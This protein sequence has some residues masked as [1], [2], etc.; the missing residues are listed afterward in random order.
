[1]SGHYEKLFICALCKEEFKGDP[2][3]LPCQHSVCESPCLKKLLGSQPSKCPRCSQE[4]NVSSNTND[5]PT[6]M[7]LKPLVSYYEGYDTLPQKPATELYSDDY[8]YYKET[9]A[10]SRNS[11]KSSV[12]NVD[13]D[14][15][16]RIIVESIS[17]IHD[18][19][20]RIEEIQKNTSLILE[21]NQSVAKNGDLKRLYQTFEQ[22]HIDIKN[23]L[24]SVE[25]DLANCIDNNILLTHLWQCEEHLS[26][27]LH[28]EFSD[29]IDDVKQEFKKHSPG[30]RLHVSVLLDCNTLPTQ[31][32]ND[33]TGRYSRSPS[34]QGEVPG[35]TAPHQVYDEISIV[36]PSQIQDFPRSQSPIP[37][38]DRRIF[39]KYRYAQM[40]AHKLFDFLRYCY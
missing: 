38:N 23:Y 29:L 34:Q 37:S 24:Q 2:K 15:V 40:F 19:I 25:N 22:K 13:I 4:L 1:M 6:D 36:Q 30:D 17:L 8:N 11:T 10:T 31:L 28:I 7:V 5:F 3:R 12:E 16:R 27:L 9:K 35:C 18:S 21:Y 20:K 32:N 26:T 33:S 39:C 14:I